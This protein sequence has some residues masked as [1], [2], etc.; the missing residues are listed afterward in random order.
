MD[1]FMGMYIKWDSELLWLFKSWKTTTSGYF[2]ISIIIWMGV[3]ALLTFLKYLRNSRCSYLENK[4]LSYKCK[5]GNFWQGLVLT[6]LI[7]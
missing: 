1:M 3:L 2:L 4:K 6:S 5:N 7:Y